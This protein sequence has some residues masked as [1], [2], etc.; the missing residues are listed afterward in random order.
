[1]NSGYDEEIVDKMMNTSKDL[2]R[3]LNPTKTP[4][5][6]EKCVIRWVTLS[7]GNFE[8]EIS[9]FVKQLNIKLKNQNVVIE[10]IKTTGPSLSKLLFNNNGNEKNSLMCGT[11]N[12]CI[13]N[14]R[15]NTKIVKSSTRSVDYRIDQN[16]GCERSGI[17]CVTCSCQTQ[18]TGK[19]TVPYRKRFSEHFMKDSKSAV[20]G[21]TAKC[22]EGK[23]MGDYTMQFLEDVWSRGKYTLSER[24][25][26]WDHRIKGSMNIQ[27][28]LKT[29]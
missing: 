19:T 11:C 22:N 6:R 15:G 25:H 8:S 3:H 27:K 13:D 18:Y 7:N 2:V 20:F 21:H 28:I 24:E 16:L 17:Y 29:S 4:P 5:T 12:I 23:S 10:N 9:Q 26:L 1:M 14:R